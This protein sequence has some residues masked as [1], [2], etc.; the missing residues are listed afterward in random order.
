MPNGITSTFDSKPMSSVERARCARL[1]TT[2]AA[3]RRSTRRVTGRYMDRRESACWVT[4]TG[5]RLA[6]SR[7]APP[8]GEPDWCDLLATA[9]ELTAWGIHDC[10]LRHVAPRLPVDAVVISGGGARNPELMARLK[11]R[12]GPIPVRTSDSYGLPVDAKEAIAF[13]ILASER[14]DQRPANLPSVTGAVGRVLLGKI[15]EC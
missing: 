5:V 4:T 7:Q 6:R 10:Y 15:T 2:T 8:A 14:L 13:A 12:F 9:T 11:A 1:G 3:A